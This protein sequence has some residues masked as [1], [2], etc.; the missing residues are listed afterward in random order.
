VNQHP[1]R[2]YTYVYDFFGAWVNLGHRPGTGARPTHC[3]RLIA[4]VATDLGS[5]CHE[6]RWPCQSPPTRAIR[7]VCHP[8]DEAT[9][10][11]RM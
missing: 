11:S 2:A 8:S 7:D 1:W 9:K 5:S 10:A 4:D 6:R 3:V